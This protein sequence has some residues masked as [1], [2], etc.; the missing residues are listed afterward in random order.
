MPGKSS[1]G[2]IGTVSGGAVI[3]S[4]ALDSMPGMQVPGDCGQ[5]RQ[6]EMLRHRR[7]SQG[8]V[9]LKA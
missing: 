7:G 5:E 3:G 8:E 2:E 4:N 9:R 6:M 1:V